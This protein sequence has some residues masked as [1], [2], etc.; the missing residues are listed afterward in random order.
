MRTIV[1]AGLDPAIR[2]KR[3]VEEWMAAL[4]GAEVQAVQAAHDER[5]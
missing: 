5:S 3:A 4:R 2:P 1:I